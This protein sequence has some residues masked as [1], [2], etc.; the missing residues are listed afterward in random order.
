VDGHICEDFADRWC[1]FKSL[2]SYREYC[3]NRNEVQ[4]R[5][6]REKMSRMIVERLNQPV[7]TILAECLSHVSGVRLVVRTAAGKRVSFPN[8]GLQSP[9]SLSHRVFCRESF[10]NISGCLSHSHQRYLSLPLPQD[11]RS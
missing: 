9:M 4:M 11:L 6:I 1:W 7:L 5:A 2:K 10:E 3:C 8:Q